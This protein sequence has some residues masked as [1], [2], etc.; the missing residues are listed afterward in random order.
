MPEP[1]NPSARFVLRTL[2]LS[3]LR[4]RILS[5][6]HEELQRRLRNRSWKKRAKTKADEILGK[7]EIASEES[8]KGKQGLTG[9]YAETEIMD[10]MSKLGSHEWAVYEL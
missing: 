6:G 2:V 7:R 9:Y 8:K 4:T 5:S 1:Q 3:L 10:K